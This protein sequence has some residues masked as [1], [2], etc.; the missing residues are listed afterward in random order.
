MVYFGLFV[1]C[2]DV[3][4]TLKTIQSFAFKDKVRKLRRFYA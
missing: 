1:L 3:D 4:P 2:E